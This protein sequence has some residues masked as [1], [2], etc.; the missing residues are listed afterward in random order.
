MSRQKIKGQWYETAVDFSSTF[1]SLFQ[2]IELKS[3]LLSKPEKKEGH[4]DNQPRDGA[5]PYQPGIPN[6]PRFGKPSK[7]SLHKPS[8]RIPTRHKDNLRTFWHKRKARILKRNETHRDESDKEEN[9][10]WMMN[11]LSRCPPRNFNWIHLSGMKS[12]FFFPDRHA[13]DNRKRQG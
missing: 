11:V 2:F 12:L 10:E 4:I 1:D 13:G 7:K 3:K 5:T 9:A 8:P 6:P